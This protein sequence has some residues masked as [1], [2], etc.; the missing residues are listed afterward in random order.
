LTNHSF[1]GNPQFYGR[2]KGRKLSRSGQFAI[3]NGKDYLIKEKDISNIIDNKNNVILEIGFGDGENLINSAKKNSN[4]FY[5]G[6]DPFLNTTAKCLSKIL[7]Y[8]LKN[9]V[10][11]PDDIR[12]ILKFLPNNSISEIKI[13]FPDPWP[14][15]KHRNR[16][17]IQD[18]F[19]KTL[20][21][22]IKHQGIITIATDHD[23]LKKWILEQ[24]QKHTDFDWMVE[25][26]NDWRQRPNDCFQTK[27]ELKSINHLRRPSWF[28]FKKK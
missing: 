24:F 11:W 23:L 19:I 14:K 28:I 25:S 22:L 13:L 20:Y 5:I 7:E 27:Y 16:R 17:L 2:R 12:K 26:A 10:I 18:E 21:S 6:A 9:I 4:F 8:N 3:R 1:S 15:K